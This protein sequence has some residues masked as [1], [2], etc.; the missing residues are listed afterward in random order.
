VKLQRPG[1]LAGIA[2]I[3]MT[4]VLALS[5]CGSDNNTNPNTNNTGGTGV[6]CKTGTLTAQGSS[7][8]GNA[9]AQWVKD[10]QTKC[11]GATINYQVTSSGAGQQAFIGGTADFAGSDSPF[12]AADQPKADS[13]CASGPA[14]HL[15]MVVGPIAVVFNVSGVSDL[16][17][18]PATLA[19]IFSGAITTWNDP[20]IVADN[21]GA[22]LPAT[23]IISVHR[24]ESSGTTDNFTK[25]LGVAAAS[26]WTFAHDKTW[27][28]PGGDAEK[29][30]DGISSFLS[31]T[32]GAIGYVE[33]SFAQVNNLK[34]AKIQ[35]GAGEFTALTGDA[36]GKTVASAKTGGASTDDMQLTIDYN[37]TASG[38]YPIVLVTYEIVCEKG[39]PAASLTLLKS[40]LTYTSSSA[41]QASL[42]GI[43]YAPLPESVR[44]KVATTVGSLS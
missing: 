41:G 43:G 24:S 40:F 8:Q 7:A 1:T 44:S 26:D 27:K 14:I 16:Q 9:M 6:D 31:K 29:G 37:T 42:S 20:A 2:G 18:K 11:A 39:T 35:N 25:Y 30:S 4:A 3:A 34:M 32:D 22:T 15:P 12:V 5:G 10:Y 36:A 21:T 17:L 28:A 19:K 13:R 33:W 38:A 23:K